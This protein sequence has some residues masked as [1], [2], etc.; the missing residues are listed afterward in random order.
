MYTFTFTDCEYSL[1]VRASA[2]VMCVRNAGLKPPV[3]YPGY[4]PVHSPIN[5]PV[6]SR[7]CGFAPTYVGDI[8]VCMCVI[9]LM[10]DVNS[11]SVTST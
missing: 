2:E 9:W 10:S 3:T 7:T 11:F 8:S 5:Y 4:A 6:T 1:S